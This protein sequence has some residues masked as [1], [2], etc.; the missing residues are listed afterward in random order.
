MY[1]EI[2]KDIFNFIEENTKSDVVVLVH[3]ISSDWALG[4]GIA[5]KIDEVFDEKQA[6][7]D[8]FMYKGMTPDWTGEGYPLVHNYKDINETNLM[9]AN[10]VTKE[11]YWDKP[12]YT[13][14]TEALKRTLDICRTVQGHAVS[15]GK[16]LKIVMPKIGCGLDGLKWNIVSD[17][18]KRMSDNFDITVCYL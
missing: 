3:C 8:T 15:K 1:Q 13:T 18:I 2:Q 7:K 17:V 6:L 5:K 14:L 10:L 12:T 9:I 16:K 11:K 4:A